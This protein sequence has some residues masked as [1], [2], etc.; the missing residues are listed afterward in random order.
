MSRVMDERRA[1]QTQ[2]KED[3]ERRGKAFFPYA[4]FHDTVMSLVVVFVIVGLACVW[5]FTA[6]E[7]AEGPSH[8]GW[9][10]VLYEGEADPG[11]TSF[12]PRKPLA[13]NVRKN[14]LQNGSA[15]D[16]PTASPSTS[17]RPS[18]LTA[19]AII[20]ATEMILP[21]SRTLT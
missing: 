8:P 19:T 2:Y 3:V 5:Y 9:L 1:Y 14:L 13:V 6:E 15:S 17:R 4:M 10:G 20:T 11:T 21:A 16:G 7:T 18:V 12:T